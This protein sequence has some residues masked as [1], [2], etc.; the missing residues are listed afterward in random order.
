MGAVGEDFAGFWG[1]GPEAGVGGVAE[2]VEVELVVVVFG[3][4]LLVVCLVF[5]WDGDYGAVRTDE[6]LVTAVVSGNIGGVA[7][8]VRGFVWRERA[9]EGSAV[10]CEFV[11]DGAVVGRGL[12][13]G[14]FL[15]MSGSIHTGQ[16]TGCEV[17]GVWFGS[18]RSLTP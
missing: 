12:W 14:L 18:D 2:G 6:Q 8:R 11:R 9:G 15:R 3:I 5:L 17:S 16:R 4:G 10:N 1:K 13:G 7:C